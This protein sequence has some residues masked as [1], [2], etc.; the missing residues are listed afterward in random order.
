MRAPAFPQNPEHQ[1]SDCLRDQAFRCGKE[2]KFGFGGT[3]GFGGIYKL[4]L[5]DAVGFADFSITTSNLN[6]A[7]LKAGGS[8]T[9][10]VEIAVIAG[11]GGS[12]SLI[13]NVQPSP[14]EGAKMRTQSELHKPWRRKHPDF[15]YHS[16]VEGAA[17]RGQF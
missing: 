6:P 11:F 14:A 7:L 9:S 17:G 16:T 1:I 2:T 3:S 15:D 10:T 13:C 12:V 5:P 8:A 4:E